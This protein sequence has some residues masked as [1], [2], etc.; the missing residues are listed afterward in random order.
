MTPEFTTSCTQ[1]EG[2]K[3]CP[4][5]AIFYFPALAAGSVSRMRF[6]AMLR[7]MARS[8]AIFF[9]LTLNRDSLRP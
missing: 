8:S 5:I 1:P 2:S 6:R 3:Q 4:L 7:L 9:N